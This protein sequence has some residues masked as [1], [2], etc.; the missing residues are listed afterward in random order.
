MLPA[1]ASW[2]TQVRPLWRGAIRGVAGADR[3]DSQDEFVGVLRTNPHVRLLAPRYRE[4]VIPSKAKDHLRSLDPGKP[5]GGESPGRRPRWRLALPAAVILVGACLSSACGDSP[6]PRVAT[7]ATSSNSEARNARVRTAWDAILTTD[8]R[9]VYRRLRSI[10]VSV[11][12]KVVVEQYRENHPAARTLEI[13]SI[14]KSVLST[15][16]GIAIDE[17]KIA[18]VD[19]TLG[20]LL[21]EYA[22]AMSDATKAVTLRQLLTMTAGLSTAD[23]IIPPDGT[24]DWVRY[25]LRSD[26][27]SPPLGQFGYSNAD[28]HVLAAVLR[29][30]TGQPPLDYARA[31]L[32]DPL[33]INSAQAKTLTATT[34]NL[35]TYLNEPGFVW[36]ADPGGLHLG[37]LGLKLT[38]RDLLS[39]G[40]L[41]LNEGRSSGQQLISA[42]WIREATQ[43]QA[44]TG[45]TQTPG[46]GYQT[47]VTTAN[48]HPAYAARGFAGQLIEVVPDLHVVVVV[49]STSPTRIDAPVEPGT[50]ESGEYISLVNTVIAPA[51]S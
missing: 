11:D 14:T 23:S 24:T 39:L 46:Y 31:H 27:S 49:Q 45:D 51:A 21:P 3:S 38:G 7:P 33:H 1:P 26:P 6:E 29:K 40:Q 13:Q 8:D 22:D 35:P 44:D 36:L 25:A 47:W 5:R 43:K 32:F 48:G 19:E 12:D 4:T 42:A 41:W 18:G 15:L 9:G 30:A 10:L 20:K 28:S 17:G 34:E 2:P 37:P 50:A 16:I